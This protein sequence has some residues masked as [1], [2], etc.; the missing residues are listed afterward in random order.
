MGCAQKGSSKSLNIISLKA[1][2]IYLDGVSYEMHN[3]GVENKQ[4]HTDKKIETDL[5][6]NLNEHPLFRIFFTSSESCGER[7]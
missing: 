7:D 1:I 5:Y 2:R 3:N 4:T 6:S